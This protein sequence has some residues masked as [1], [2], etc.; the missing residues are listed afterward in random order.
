ML[1]GI[2][3]TGGVGV[4][5]KSSVAPLVRLAC[6]HLQS[7]LAEVIGDN[8]QS[9]R[10]MCLNETE[11]TFVEPRDDRSRATMRADSLI[12]NARDVRVT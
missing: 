8:A 5:K 12:G 6:V 4:E 3:L 7:S 2:V 11:S 10:G 9:N 1:T